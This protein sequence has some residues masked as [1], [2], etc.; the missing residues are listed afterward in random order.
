LVLDKVSVTVEV[1]PEVMEVGENALPIDG[2][3]RTVRVAVL[4]AAPA[5]GV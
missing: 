2:V 1:P 4:L 5:D 3:A